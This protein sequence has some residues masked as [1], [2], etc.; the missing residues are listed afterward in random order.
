MAEGMRY[1]EGTAGVLRSQEQILDR[2][3]LLMVANGETHK[4]RG[5][6]LN[7]M[8][9]FKRGGEKPSP[10]QLRK[11]GADV[12][13]QLQAEAKAT[14]ATLREIKEKNPEMLEPLMLA[15]EASNGDVKTI[16]ALNN[17]FRQSTG[18]IK[19]ALVD[20]SAR[21]PLSHHGWFLVECI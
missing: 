17:Y 15:Y 16:D 19:K 9:L 4:Q 20:L 10:A 18:V 11:A 12:V 2:I 14:V 1:A 5:L 8:N 21:Y 7:L 3:E 13:K 6:L